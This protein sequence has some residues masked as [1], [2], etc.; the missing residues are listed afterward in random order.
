MPKEE[1][2]EREELIDDLIDENDLPEDTEVPLDDIEIETL[3]NNSNEIMPRRVEYFNRIK[4]E[5]RAFNAYIKPMS[6][7]KHTS[8][9]NLVRK[10]K[11]KTMVDEVLKRYLFNSKGEQLSP[12]Q[13][14][15]LDAGLAESIYE[16]IRF[17]SGLFR[18]KGQELIVKEIV[19]ND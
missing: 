10:N 6:H 13:I 3:I 14:E 12:D 16:E 8:L 4:N 1:K 9:Q 19:K 17:I 11:T 15:E 2:T 7:G 18:D 5:K